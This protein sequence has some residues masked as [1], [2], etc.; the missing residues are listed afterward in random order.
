[1]RS[2]SEKNRA[3]LK[4]SLHLHLFLFT[5]HPTCPQ[6]GPPPPPPSDSL[7]PSHHHLSSRCH[8]VDEFNQKLICHCLGKH[9]PGMGASC[10]LTHCK[11]NPVLRKPFVTHLKKGGVNGSSEVNRAVPVVFVIHKT[12]SISASGD[13]DSLRDSGGQPKVTRC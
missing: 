2:R 8:V 1:M 3:A 12:L 13:L 10:A 7:R 11:N 9:T 5:Q 6:S 4:G